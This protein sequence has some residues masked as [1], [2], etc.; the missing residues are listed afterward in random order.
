MMLMLLLRCWLS[1]CCRLLVV[2][3]WMLLVVVGCW[4]LLFVVVG[5]LAVFSRELATPAFLHGFA[6]HAAWRQ[7][8]ELPTAQNGCPFKVLLKMYFLRTA[9]AKRD[10]CTE[11]AKRAISALNDSS[12]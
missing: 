3:V 10:G 5:L 8:Q 1:G 9:S 4:L 12:L 7:I 11:R 6:Q 2:V